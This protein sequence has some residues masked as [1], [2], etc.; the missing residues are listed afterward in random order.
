[1]NKT[2]WLIVGGV[3]VVG[4]LWYFSHR[5]SSSTVLVSPTP[6]KSPVAAKDTTDASLNSDA[7]ALDAEMKGVSADLTA[8]DN[9]MNDKPIPQAQ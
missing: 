6:S 5:G 8:S 2:L 7:A 1:M 4:G 3:V 9:A